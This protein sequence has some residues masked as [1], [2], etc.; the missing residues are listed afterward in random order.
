M[1]G[2]QTFNSSITDDGGIA[3]TMPDGS[4]VDQVGM[5]A[6]SAFKE[7]TILAP[8]TTNENRSYERKL[9][10]ANGNCYDTN[11]S[12]ADFAVTN[13]SA[14]RNLASPAVACAIPA[15]PT[16][17]G[18]TLTPNPGVTATNTPIGGNTISIQ[19]NAYLP[20]TLTIVV[21]TTVIWTNKDATQHTI[22]SGVPGAA[23]S[24]LQSNVLN[25]GDVFSY[26]F[27]ATGTFPFFDEVKGGTGSITVK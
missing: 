21:G 3:L 16:P 6:G 8:L 10:G 15:T 11:N 7:G 18:P 14:P 12:A 2:D 26:T 20:S 1:T 27:Q 25:A 4:M 23:T 13:P 5:S 9:T 22:R 17:G 19:N 24:P